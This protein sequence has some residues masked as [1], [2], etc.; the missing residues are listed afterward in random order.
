MKKNLIIILFLLG[1]PVFSFAHARLEKQ[2]ADIESL[3]VQGGSLEVTYTGSAD[4]QE[5]KIVAF[6]GE[7]KERENDLV[8]V[9]MDKV[10]KI[11]FQPNKK[12]T[13]YHG[14]KRYIHITG[15]EAINLTISNSSGQVEATHI[16]SPSTQLAITSGR[17][18]ASAIKG[19]L[20]L[21]G[22]S[23]T[24][25]AKDIDGSVVCKITSGRSTVENVAGN[26]DFSSSSG[27]LQATRVGGK[28]D[29]QL[30]SGNVSLH[31]I[32]ELGEIAMSSGNV[33]ATGVGLGTG[34]NLKATSGSFT[35][36]TTSSLSDFNYDLKASS[37][38]LAV[39]ESS[40]NK[41]LAIENGAPATVRGSVS[42]GRIRI[43]N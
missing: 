41:A 9:P 21:R 36:S 11:A 12:F 14:P 2:Y 16:T 10:L 4:Q 8:F 32:G 38:S 18:K 39:G 34:T 7:E 43:D 30:T 19:D 6:L 26:L 33:K 17:L 13:N 42:S 3:D 22:S 29:V 20:T 40:G 5:I 25:E 35:I 24:I 28:V 23:C 37:G 31:T 1:L 15:P 27:S